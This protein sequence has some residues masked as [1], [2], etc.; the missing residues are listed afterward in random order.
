MGFGFGAGVPGDLLTVG[1]ALR[2]AL[3]GLVRT[4]AAALALALAPV[5]SAEHPARAASSTAAA[6]V[7]AT[8]F[9]LTPVSRLLTTE[10]PT[11]AGATARGDAP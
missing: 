10:K 5:A 8:N 1:A 11:R 6:A 4:F 7:A 9:G 3:A 2:G